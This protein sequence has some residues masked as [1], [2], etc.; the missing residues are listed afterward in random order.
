ML[1]HNFTYFDMFGNMFIKRKMP[2]YKTITCLFIALYS[3]SLCFFT[4]IHIRMHVELL[5]NKTMQPF[6]HHM[7]FSKR[8]YVQTKK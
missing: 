7:K 1:Q 8:H 5:N 4:Y 6:F 3:L 2:S